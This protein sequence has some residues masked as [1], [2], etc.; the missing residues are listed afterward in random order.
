M[1]SGRKTPV[2]RGQTDPL[3]TPLPTEPAMKERDTWSAEE[4]TERE[5]SS[6]DR[7]IPPAAVITEAIASGMGR[8]AGGPIPGEV[9]EPHR[10]HGT[11]IADTPKPV[12]IEGSS[13]EENTETDRGDKRSLA[14]THEQIARR[15]YEF[16]LERGQQTGD[17]REDW[18]RAEKEL[19]EK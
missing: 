4:S 13:V 10:K 19:S 15:A 18:Q 5:A 7:E 11:I 14:P 8:P 3:E 12:A 6:Q 17:A 16:Y 9:D 2:T 1:E